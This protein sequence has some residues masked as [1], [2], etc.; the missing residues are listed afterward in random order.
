[1]NTFSLRH[2]FLGAHYVGLATYFLLADASV[3][4]LLFSLWCEMVLLLVLYGILSARYG[5]GIQREKAYRV[6]IG[7]IVLLLFQLCGASAVSIWL[8]EFTPEQA[9]GSSGLARPIH[10]FSTSILVACGS[11]VLIYALAVY[12]HIVQRWS[13][14]ELE[15]GLIFQAL[16]L[17]GVGLLTI[18]LCGAFTERDATPILMCCAMAR[19]TAQPFLRRWVHSP[20]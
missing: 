10:A 4:M 2:V 12:D 13:L 3:F 15:R 11:L 5:S 18:I 7:S 17:T 1:M 8:N 20:R 19:I 14:E 6:I 16:L 9:A